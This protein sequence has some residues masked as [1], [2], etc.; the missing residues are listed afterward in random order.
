MRRHAG[1]YFLLSLSGWSQD[2]SA[3]VSYL[4]CCPAPDECSC[5]SQLSCPRP[6]RSPEGTGRLLLP[7]ERRRLSLRSASS[8]L[9]QSVCRSVVPCCCSSAHPRPRLPSFSRLSKEPKSSVPPLIKITFLSAA[10]A[11]NGV[12][13]WRRWMLW[14]VLR[15]WREERAVSHHRPD[16]LCCF[17]KLHHSAQLLELTHTCK[18]THFPPQ[19]GELRACY[20]ADSWSAAVKTPL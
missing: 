18:H 3:V 17:L 4:T 19:T 6:P 10:S 12:K 14:F 11:L 1:I 15:C 8:R 7:Q 2:S 16:V 13:L 9:G 20:A 5:P